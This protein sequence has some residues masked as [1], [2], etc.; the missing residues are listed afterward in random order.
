MFKVT[1]SDGRSISVSASTEAEAT[2]KAYRLE[3]V[4]TVS[5]VVAA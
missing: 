5:A 1:F 4:Y 2:R 3:P